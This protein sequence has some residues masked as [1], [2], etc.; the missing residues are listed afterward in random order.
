MT[1]KNI[2]NLINLINTKDEIEHH[3]FINYITTNSIYFYKFITL[4]KNNKSILAKIIKMLNINYDFFIQTINVINTTFKINNHKKEYSHEYYII[5][6]CQLLNNHNQWISLKFNILANNPNKFHYKSINK[7]FILYTKK[8][9]F[10]NTFYNTT[11]NNV[12]ISNNNDLLID[13]S[14][15]ANKL[16]S[17]NVTVNCEYTKK[18]CTKLSFIANT[19]KIILSVTPYKIND[20]EIDYDKINLIKKQKQEVKQQKKDKLKQIMIENKDLKAKLINK[21]KCYK[22]KENTINNITTNKNIEIIKEEMKK[23][24]ENII[25]KKNKIKTST[26]DVMMIQTS[27]NN[28]KTIFTDIKSITLTGDLGYLSSKIYKLNNQNIQLITPKRKNQIKKNTENER[29]KLCSRYKIE[30]CFGLLKQ[31]ERIMIR[32]DKKMKTFMSFI[33]MA[34]TIENNKIINKNKKNQ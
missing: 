2:Q 32:K 6:I 19:D 20:K 18:N 25:S 29:I 33:Y 5:L 10:K 22:K 7:Q 28:I 1:N 27:L 14:M 23:K 15:I 21:L 30:N 16:G 34:C 31:Y 8:D 11:I 24:N 4:I 17:E 26:H 12:S 9:I 13:A 3:V